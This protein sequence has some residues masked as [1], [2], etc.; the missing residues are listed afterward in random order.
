MRTNGVTAVFIPGMWSTSKIF[1]PMIQVFEEHNV[2]VKTIDLDRTSVGN[3]RPADYKTQVDRALAKIDAPFPIG[4]SMGGW[5]AQAAEAHD[6]DG[7]DR[8]VGRGLIS[9]A[10]F[11]SVFPREDWTQMFHTNWTQI[12]SLFGQLNQITES[13]VRPNKWWAKRL[14]KN[15][16]GVRKIPWGWD[17]DSHPL[18]SR[19]VLHQFVWGIGT[20]VP[21][22]K[23]TYVVVGSHDNLTPPVKAA[24][25][26]SYHNNGGSNGHLWIVPNHDHDSILYD[27]NVAHYFANLVLSCS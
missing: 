15:M 5:L 25:T 13:A 27:R 3:L 16:H 7:N 17:I 18:E 12:L 1:A 26:A 10:P 14:A 21:R 11:N 4:H 9:P 8:I 23:N 19:W 20:Q 24:E 2:P 6:A 22:R